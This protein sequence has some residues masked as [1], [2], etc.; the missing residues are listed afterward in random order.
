MPSP[1]RI[2]IFLFA[3]MARLPLSCLFWGLG[4]TVFGRLR[5]SQSG[6]GR[7][8]GERRPGRR[9]AAE[10]GAVGG[11][12]VLSRRL[13]GEVE[14]TVERR[15]QRCARRR[16]PGP[17]VGVGIAGE[18]VGHPATG[19]YRREAAAQVRAGGS[20]KLSME[21]HRTEIQELERSLFSFFF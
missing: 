10:V 19:G 2:N 14:A 12:E 11:G 5:L 6:F 17:R 15:V 16:G 3:A 13:A 21:E 18:G 4:L 8:V 7:K 1:G 9:E 20:G